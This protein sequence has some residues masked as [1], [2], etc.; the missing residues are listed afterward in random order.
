[1]WLFRET[2]ENGMPKTQSR[3]L[4]H[5]TRHETKKS[6]AVV[7]VQVLA[8]PSLERNTTT[9]KVLLLSFFVEGFA[10]RVALPGSSTTSLNGR[11]T[12]IF[13]SSYITTT[14]LVTSV[15]SSLMAMSVLPKQATTT[16]TTTTHQRVSNRETQPWEAWHGVSVMH[17]GES[18]HG[19]EN[20][21]KIQQNQPERGRRNSFIERRM[22]CTTDTSIQ[23]RNHVTRRKSEKKEQRRTKSQK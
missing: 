16:T 21:A 10:Q 20:R 15:R 13:H 6:L 9:N 1:M 11:R 5:V 7:V 17:F 8:L 23:A 2:S 19:Q 12:Q 22:I 14:S 3:Q 18:R 4:P